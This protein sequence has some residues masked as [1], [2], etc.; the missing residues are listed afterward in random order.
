VALQGWFE[1]KTARREHSRIINRFREQGLK[2]SGRHGMD[3]PCVRTP[4]GSNR[5]WRALNDRLDFL[6]EML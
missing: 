4:A 2:G 3:E 1:R 5:Y 6:S